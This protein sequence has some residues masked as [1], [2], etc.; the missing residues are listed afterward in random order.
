[1]KE[2]IEYIIKK[3]R[4]PFD[5]KVHAIPYAGN[6]FE[7]QAKVL[8][9]EVLKEIESILDSFCVMVKNELKQQRLDGFSL[10]GTDFDEVFKS[11]EKT[12]LSTLSPNK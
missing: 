9:D 8:A 10:D 3:L 11:A 2:G 5:N 4:K 6:L 7:E 1:M 12:I